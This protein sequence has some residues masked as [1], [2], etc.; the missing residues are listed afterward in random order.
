[1]ATCLVL[2]NPYAYG[3]GLARALNVAQEGQAPL[4]VVFFIDLPGIRDLVEDLGEKG[5]LGPGS[6]RTLEEAMR[7]GYRALAEDVLTEIQRRTQE[8]GV[9]AEF[10]VEEGD[11]VRYVHT[12]VHQGGCKV[13]ISGGR[14][15]SDRL[16][17]ILGIEVV[18]E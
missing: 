18:P 4:R 1:M 13:L 3:H 6:V 9:P 14:P 10:L 16:Q 11:L 5:W 8:A 2:T 7:A 17:G 15:L 12:L